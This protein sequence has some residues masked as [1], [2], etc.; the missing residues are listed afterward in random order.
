M[1][2]ETQGTEAPDVDA[3]ASDNG[4]RAKGAVH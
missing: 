3:N 4:D 1:S 2:D